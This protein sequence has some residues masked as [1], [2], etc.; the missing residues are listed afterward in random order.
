MNLIKLG[1][2]KGLLA[3]LAIMFA[4]V[5]PASADLASVCPKIRQLGADQYKSNSPVRSNSNLTAPIVRFGLNPTIIFVASNPARLATARAYDKK[6]GLL[7]TAQR[8]GCAAKPRSA[9]LR[10][11]C[12]SRYKADENRANTRAMRRLA[13]RRTGSPEVYWKVASNLCIR[14]ADLGKCYNVKVRE[15]CDGRIIG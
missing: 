5:A 11:T 8:L 3:S 2:V 15:L 10:G 12:L 4:V 13:I 7:F 9:A 1:R 14:V 6:G